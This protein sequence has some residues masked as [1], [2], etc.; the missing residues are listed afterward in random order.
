MVWE[1]PRADRLGEQV[2][3]A[4]LARDATTNFP[5]GSQEHPG[6]WIVYRVV[7]RKGEQ[8]DKETNP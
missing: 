1:K 2:N 5:L 4:S 8:D 3:A 7:I 6:L